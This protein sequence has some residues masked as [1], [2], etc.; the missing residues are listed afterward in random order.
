VEEVSEGGRAQ[1]KASG[2]TRHD[3]S[4]EV[5][6]GVSGWADWERLEEDPGC[7]GAAADFVASLVDAA[8]VAQQVQH[9]MERVI[10]V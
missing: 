3:G 5:V 2:G 1:R 7:F 9:F 8:V 4:A 6:E 10:V